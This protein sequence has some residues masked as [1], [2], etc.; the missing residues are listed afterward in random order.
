VI[1]VEYD[2]V[3]GGG[4]RPPALLGV[5]RAAFPASCLGSERTAGK[6]GIQDELTSVLDGRIVLPEL[7]VQ[8]Y[9][10]EKDASGGPKG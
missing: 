5:V 6:L 3:A 4:L 8:Y 9:N 10:N 7:R 1:V 2:G